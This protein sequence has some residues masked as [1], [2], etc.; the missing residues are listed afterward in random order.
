[1]GNGP[2]ALHQAVLAG[3]L[4]AVRVAVQ[5]QPGSLDDTEPTVSRPCRCALRGPESS[6]SASRSQRT[7]TS[8]L[9]RRRC[10]RR[11]VLLPLLACCTQNGWTPLHI[12]AAK[13]Y[14]VIAR[15]LL[16]RGAAPNLVDKVRA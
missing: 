11:C 2:S 9:L 13:G 5:Q 16:A 6:S 10:G 14:D 4:T 15:E 8:L 1:M 7:P 3:D 12:S